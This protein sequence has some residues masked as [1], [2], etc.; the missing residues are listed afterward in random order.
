MKALIGLT[1]G[2]FLGY[3]FQVPV[4]EKIFAV[5]MLAAIDSIC[6]GFSAKLNSNFNDT[7]LICGFFTNL[8]FGLILILLG[9]FFELELYYIALLIFGLRIFK[10]ISAAQELF[11]KK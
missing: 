5:I 4:D 9:N 6:G 1:A 10:N 7:I 2:F 8:I 3:I 11:L